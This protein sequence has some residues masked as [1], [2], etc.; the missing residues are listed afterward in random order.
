MRKMSITPIDD[1]GVLRSLILII[2]PILGFWMLGIVLGWNG[3]EEEI[4]RE[5]ETERQRERTRVGKRPFC[6]SKFLI[7]IVGPN[8]LT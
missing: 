8:E 6:T 4:E 5:R 2:L 7:D 3:R 1:A